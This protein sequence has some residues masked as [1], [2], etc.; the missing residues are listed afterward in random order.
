MEPHVVSNF[1]APAFI[2][3][4]ILDAG[5]VLVLPSHA[6]ALDVTL[7]SADSSGASCLARNAP[8]GLPGQ[9]RLGANGRTLRS[10]PDL[11]GRTRLWYD[12]G[13]GR[14]VCSFYECRDARIVFP[15]R[16]TR[17][18]DRAR[19]AFAKSRAQIRRDWLRLRRCAGL[20]IIAGS[21]R[22]SGRR[23]G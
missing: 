19:P 21:V 13:L 7:C 5:T 16:L 4:W 6:Q 22:Q 12:P 18:T 17:S 23:H 8:I 10:I 11:A 3:G 9:T 2:S 14:S 20:F 1:R 15:G